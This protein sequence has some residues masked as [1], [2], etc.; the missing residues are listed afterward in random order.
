MSNVSKT[1]ELTLLTE[2]CLING[3]FVRGQGQGHGQKLQMA[4][5]L[6]NRD[7]TRRV[8]AARGAGAQP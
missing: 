8:R 7:L 3:L 4:P 6:P 5:A 1:M 2:F